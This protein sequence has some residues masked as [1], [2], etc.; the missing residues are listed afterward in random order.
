MYGPVLC[1]IRMSEKQGITEFSK[2][3]SKRSIIVTN[4]E[5]DISKPSESYLKDVATMYDIALLDIKRL[6][7]YDDENVKR[8]CSELKRYKLVLLKIIRSQLE[9]I[10]IFTEEELEKYHA[11]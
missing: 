6:S 8:G 10:P 9:N 4:N 1:A 2:K 5:D 7:L 11:K 3:I